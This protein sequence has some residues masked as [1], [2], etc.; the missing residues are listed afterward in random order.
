MIRTTN[1]VHIQL[2]RSH[3]TAIK[4]EN[5]N[6]LK[7]Y[8]AILSETTIPAFLPPYNPSAIIIREGVGRMHGEYDNGDT[9]TKPTL[10]EFLTLSIFIKRHQQ[11]LNMHT[12]SFH[13]ISH[14]KQ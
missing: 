6:I 13:H 12:H 14:P 3:Y 5:D 9:Q 7:G 1:I 2:N 8:Y 4:R 11:Y 10:D